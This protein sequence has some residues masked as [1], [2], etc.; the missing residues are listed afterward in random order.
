MHLVESAVCNLIPEPVE[1]A[2]LRVAFADKKERVRQR[3]AETST[4][5]QCID[6]IKEALQ[7]QKI[8]KDDFFSSS[9]SMCKPFK[10]KCFF[11]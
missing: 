2:I 8:K 6:Q 5:V 3:T 11:C 9:F 1:E 10:V 4:S 7:L